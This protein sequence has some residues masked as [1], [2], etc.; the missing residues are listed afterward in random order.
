MTLIDSKVEDFD[1]LIETNEGNY[2]A[3]CSLDFSKPPAFY[4]TFALRDSEGHEQLMMTWPYF[5][6]KS[7]REAYIQGKPVPLASCWNGMGK[8]V[9]LLTMHCS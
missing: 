1:N 9:H 3:A 7:S 2:A 6:A 8:L 5:R 4:D